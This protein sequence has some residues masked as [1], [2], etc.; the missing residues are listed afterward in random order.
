MDKVILV[1]GPT[2]VGKSSVGIEIA[3][4]WHTDIISADSIQV[5]RGLNIGSGKMTGRQ[6]QG[7]RQHLLDI[8][9][10]D[11]NYSVRDFQ[12]MGRE[13]AGR[14][15]R[16]GKIPVIVGGTGLYAKALVY[17]YSFDEEE[18]DYPD[19]V[20]GKEAWSSRELH[21]QLEE[22]DPVTARTIHPNNR[23][24]ILR[25]LYMAEAGHPRSAVLAAQKHRPVY[26]V[27]FVEC[28]RNR[29]DLYRR[30]DRR[31]DRMMEQGLEQEVESLYRK[32]PGLFSFQ[33]MQGIGYREWKEYFEGTQTREETVRRIRTDTK[34]F[35]R[36]Q[37]TWLKHQMPENWYDLS[38]K[39][40]RERIM[41]ELE[42]WI[43]VDAAA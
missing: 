29:E 41:E 43:H 23:K 4:R 40:E 31:I 10:P 35:A 9:D 34:H 3:K 8:L 2:A 16:E 30:I 11:Q 27:F 28:T 18:A 38:R 15:I 39:G 22:K 33:S 17:D 37:Y 26:E 24:R 6:A 13:I 25:A 32:Y 20:R 5:Y 1:A 42:E 12:K 7:V 36:R 21:R 19:Y 14:M